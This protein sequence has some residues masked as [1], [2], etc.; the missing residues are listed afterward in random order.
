[1]EWLKT[2]G[3]AVLSLLSDLGGAITFVVIAAGL[4]AAA[5]TGAVFGA[6]TAFPQ[7]YFTMLVVG[8]ALLATGL[9]LHF[10]RDRLRPR[11]TG[12]HDP[13]VSSSHSQAAALQRRRDA[14]EAAKK[15]RDRQLRERR[16]LG[17]VREE[18]L[19][20][21]RTLARLATDVD[22]LFALRYVEWGR[23]KTVLLELEDSS[24]YSRASAAYR[25]LRA[26]GRGRISE[27]GFSSELHA[28][29][30]P[31]NGVEIAG[32]EHAIDAAVAVL[33]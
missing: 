8:V 16:A 29:G 15:A 12:P 32:A 24:P 20:N 22:E 26:L 18:L 17:R 27:D 13:D 21:K 25:E 5:F 7:P 4:I 6:W 9:T 28:F 23:E 10:F 14:E 30:D 33:T 19:D 31:P 1:M 2:K 11:S 3:R